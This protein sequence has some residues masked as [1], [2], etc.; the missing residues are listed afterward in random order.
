MAKAAQAQAQVIAYRA[1]RIECVVVLHVFAQGAPRHLQHRLQLRV[2]GRPHAGK[3]AEFGLRGVEQPGE[4][5]EMQQQV[6]RQIDRAFSR[7]AHAQKYR[8]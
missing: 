7:H 5:A 1:R 6:A 3:G 4:P 2:L 8:Q